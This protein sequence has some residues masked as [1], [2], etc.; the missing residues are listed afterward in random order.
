MCILYCV[1]L[2]PIK[3]NQTRRTSLKNP[4]FFR[5]ASRIW[6]IFLTLS[7]SDP[8]GRKQNVEKMT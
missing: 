8:V 7:D 2:P 1:V 3:P 6:S 4:N 5:A